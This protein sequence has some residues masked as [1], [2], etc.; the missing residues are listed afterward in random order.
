MEQ[1]AREEEHDSHKETKIYIDDEMRH[2]WRRIAIP[3]FDGADTIGWIANLVV[4]ESDEQADE[5]ESM[6]RGV[7]V[8]KG[9]ENVL[10]KEL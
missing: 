4:G 8:G 2:A 1:R 3:G 10:V 6:C 7:N 5:K 9:D